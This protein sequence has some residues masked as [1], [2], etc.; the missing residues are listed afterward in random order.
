M[1]INGKNHD[2]CRIPNL[3]NFNFPVKGALFNLILFKKES[4]FHHKLEIG[5]VNCKS[6]HNN[7]NFILVILQILIVVIINNNL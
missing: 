2:R 7:N 3:K 1:Y 4:S 5:I 6:I